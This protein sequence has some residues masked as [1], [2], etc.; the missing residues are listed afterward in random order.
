MELTL[1]YRGILPAAGSVQVKHRIRQELSGQLLAY[2]G[3]L[4]RLKQLVTDIPNLQV[5]TMARD[6]FEV[7][8]P[9]ADATKFWWRWPLGGYNFVPLVTNQLESH[10]ELRM[11]LYRKNQGILFQGGDL[12]NCL[13]T[14]FDALQVPKDISQV[15][16]DPKASKRPETE[17]TPVFCLMDN[18]NLVTGLTIQSL[19]L[20][21]EPLPGFEDKQNYV[22]LELDVFIHP[23]TPMA[24]TLDLLFRGG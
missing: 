13:K 4:G 17:W 5:A 1:T 18:D 16:P 12:D 6:Q 2:W 20:L 14:F 9:L 7:P 22:E 11:R 19:R 10:V 23:I 15:P 8:R 21:T 3:Q 24:G